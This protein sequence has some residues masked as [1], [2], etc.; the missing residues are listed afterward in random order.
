MNYLNEP[1]ENNDNTMKLFNQDELR[2]KY[3]RY[4]LEC[5]KLKKSLMAC[6]LLE[7]E[8]Y[9]YMPSFPHEFHY[10]RCGARTRAGTPCKMKGIYSNTRCK[11]HGGLST[12]A[13]TKEG[14]AKVAMNGFNSKKIKQTP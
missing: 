6:G 7:Y 1:R 3:K 14:K 4:V 9:K 12:G 2:I 10:L 8:T 5:Q 11:L 13:K